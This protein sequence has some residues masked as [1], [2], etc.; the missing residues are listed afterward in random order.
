MGAH[1]DLFVASGGAVERL[2]SD[3]PVRVGDQMVFRVSSDQPSRVGVWVN[4]PEGAGEIGW[5]S[6]G[7][8]PVTLGDSYGKTAT[9]YR[10]E[11]PGRY[12]FTASTVQVGP[13]GICEPP[14]CVRTVVEV[15]P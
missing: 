2:G 11:R 14:A 10:F 9:T 4:G 5:Q 6:A 7:P 13:E 8:D 3:E 1:L 15:R 12:V